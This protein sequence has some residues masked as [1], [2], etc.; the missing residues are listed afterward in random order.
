MKIKTFT[1]NTELYIEFDGFFD[2][3]EK[4][5]EASKKYFLEVSAASIIYPYIRAFISNATALDTGNAVILP[6]INFAS[7]V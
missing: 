3:S 4:L 2:I 7:V 1:E 5:D 6:V